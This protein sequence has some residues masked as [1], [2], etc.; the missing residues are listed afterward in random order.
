MNHFK[1]FLFQFGQYSV[2]ISLFVFLSKYI[3]KPFTYVDVL[4]GVLFVAI[5][6]I[7]DT[8]TS[9]L[10]ANLLPI[11]FM[12]RFSLSLISFILV[13]ICIGFVIGEIQV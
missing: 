12:Q 1:Y 2:I 13:F 5:V 8:F 4:T 11:Q 3:G 6:V 7:L 9:K 10:R